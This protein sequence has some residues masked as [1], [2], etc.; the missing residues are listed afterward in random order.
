MGNNP[1]SNPYSTPKVDAL[2]NPEELATQDL[3]ERFLR[4]EMAVLAV[5]WFFYFIGSVLIG[6]GLLDFMIVRYRIFEFSFHWYFL[7]FILLIAG[8]LFLITGYGLRRFDSWAR[9]PAMIASVASIVLLPIGVLAAPVC[10]ILLKNNAVKDLFTPEYQTAVVAE[11]E[12][13][14]HYGWLAV[15]GGLLTSFSLFLLIYWKSK[16]FF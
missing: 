5:G 14:K 7:G 16:G 13:I 4:E 3:R 6:V 11:G 12:L 8:A 10:F 9:L 15:L 1:S 2:Q